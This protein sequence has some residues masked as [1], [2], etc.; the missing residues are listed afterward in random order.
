MRRSG[1]EEHFQFFARPGRSAHSP[2]TPTPTRA[3][4]TCSR[5]PDRR[6]PKGQ[7]DHR[8]HHLGAGRGGSPLWHRVVRRR[9][10]APLEGHPPAARQGARA[11]VAACGHCVERAAPTRLSLASSP[12]PPHTLPATA[13]T[14]PPSHPPTPTHPSPSRSPG[15][16]RLPQGHRLYHPPHGFHVRQLLHTRGDGHPHQVCVCGGGGV[17]GGGG[18]TERMR[19][20]VWRSG[21]AGL[22]A[23]R[24]LALASTH[25]PSLSP[26]PTHPHD[27][28]LAPP[29]APLAF[30][31]S[32][33]P[34][35]RR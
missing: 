1:G 35:T 6:E 17:G 14:P 7:D 5:R 23:P 30:A 12:S 29:C 8:A 26:E 10:R 19:A 31:G 9:A 33:R 13:P 2:H 25:S 11:S 28:A 27:L 3:H 16:G 20:L 18:S 15:A 4:H 32:S 21:R 24:S 34:P 22:P